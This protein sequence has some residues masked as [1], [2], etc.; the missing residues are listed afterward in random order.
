MAAVTAVTA[1]VAAV[2]AMKGA[3][4]REALKAMDGTG[5][6][7]AVVRRR[8]AMVTGARGLMVDVELVVCVVWVVCAF[9]GYR[10]AVYGLYMAWC[11]VDMVW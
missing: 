9:Y 11:D 10:V 7:V 6:W 8:R 4:A 1:A 3:A 5:A 2:A